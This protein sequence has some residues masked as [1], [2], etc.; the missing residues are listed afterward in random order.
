MSELRSL[1]PMQR[2]VL[3]VDEID[4]H[5]HPQ[6]QRVFLPALLRAAS[7]LRPDIEVQIIASTHAPLVLASVET[8]FDEEQDRV[9]SLDLH[10]GAVAVQTIPWAKQ[11][12]VVGWL[13]S[14]AFD[15]KQARSREAEQAIEAAEAL[16]RGDLEALPDGLKTQDASHRELLRVLAGHDP[17]WPRWIVH[18]EAA[19]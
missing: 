3:L 7:A 16:M 13:V 12:D 18:T 19:V 15:L 10:D 5:L 11:G 8:L 6:W 14:D 1:D 9:L 17:F 2:L 4:A